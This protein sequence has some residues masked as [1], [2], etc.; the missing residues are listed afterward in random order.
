V[1]GG[2]VAPRLG[3]AEGHAD[4]LAAVF[5]AAMAVLALLQW[6]VIQRRARTG[7]LRSISSIL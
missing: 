2:P 3:I 7:Y 1:S 6:Q 4:A 5:A